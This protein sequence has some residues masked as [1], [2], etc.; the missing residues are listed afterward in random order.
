MCRNGNCKCGYPEKGWIQFLVL[1]LLY[2]KP[3]HGYQLLE[4]IERKSCGCHKLEPGSIYT[5]LH[6]M[7]E[8]KL[9]ESRWEEAGSGPH[10]RIYKVTEKG[11]MILRGGLQII[12][13][14]KALMDDLVAFYRTHFEKKGGEK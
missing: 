7:E 13:R 6:R 10:K 3:A 14:R 9:L 5:I 4:D 8:K 2:E 1:R 12:T 11:A